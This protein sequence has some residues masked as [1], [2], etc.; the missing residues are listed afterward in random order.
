MT[1]ALNITVISIVQATGSR[2]AMKVL[3][4]TVYTGL[5]HKEDVEKTD[6]GHGLKD[7]NVGIYQ[8]LW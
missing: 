2:L 8:Y 4:Y 3:K 6:S 5:R 1:A 7:F